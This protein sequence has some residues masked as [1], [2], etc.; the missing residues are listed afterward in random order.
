MD[1]YELEFSCLL[2]FA[3]EGYIDNEKMK[4]QKFQNGLN[5]EIRHDVKIFKLT[6]LSVVVHK[7][8]VVERNKAEYR[9]QQQ[10]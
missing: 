10:Q 1:E 5:L 6:T 7:A 8:R 9:K 3:S 2:R 4:V